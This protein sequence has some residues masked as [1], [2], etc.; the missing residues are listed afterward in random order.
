MKG[1]PL[2]ELNQWSDLIAALYIL[3]HDVKISW[4]AETL[5]KYVSTPSTPVSTCK[6]ARPADIFYT[7][8]HGVRELYKQAGNNISRLRCTLRILDSFGT[9]PAYNHESYVRA[10]QLKKGYG[11]FNLNPQQYMTQWPHTPDNSFMGFVV[12]RMSAEEAEK[13]QR[14]DTWALLY[15]KKEEIIHR[16]EAKLILQVLRDDFNIQSTLFQ[17]AGSEDEISSIPAFINNHGYVNQST[18]LT[19]LR[20]S[21]IYVGLGKPPEGPAAL[22]AIANGAIF[23]QPRYEGGRDEYQSKPTE[24]VLTSQNPYME[25][26]AG[27]YSFTYDQ[28]NETDIKLVLEKIKNT[29]IK[30]FVPYPFTHEGVLKRIHAYVEHQNFCSDVDW[31]P[32]ETMKIKLGQPGESCNQVCE[33]HKEAGH[34]EKRCERSWF[35]HINSVEKL[36][37]RVS[38]CRE[39]HKTSDKIVSPYYDAKTKSCFIQRDALLYR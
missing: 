9:E 21:K 18:F 31:P 6:V 3:G 2:G 8:I 24:R 10:H 39:T 16:D 4:S 13:V 26:I 35:R 30:Q 1:G 15:G 11:Q 14:N 32:R 19:V 37:E 20:Q 12:H 36:L 22:E 34:K 7:D 23:L 33:G 17:K 38:N 27:N 25:T 28:Y 5:L 29:T